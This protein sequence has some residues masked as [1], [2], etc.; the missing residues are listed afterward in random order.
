MLGTLLAAL[1]LLT[2]ATASWHALPAAP[3]ARSEVAAAVVNG[4]IAVVGGFEPAGAASP[5]VDW[6]VPRARRWKRLPDLPVGL[7]HAMAASDGRLLYVAGGYATREQG[8]A[9][10][11]RAFVLD[12]AAAD[13]R[14]R[15]LPPMPGAR[16]AGGAAFAERHLYIIAGVRRGLP[17][18]A[19]AA[20]AYDPGSRRWRTIPGPPTAREHLGVAALG[21]RI[22]ALGGRTAG[23][24][25]NLR[26]ADAYDIAARRWSTLPRAPQARGGCAAASVSGRVLLVG[27]EEPGGTI[28]R[29]DAFDP[30]TRR[31]SSLPPSPQPRHGVGVAATGG[32]VFQLL[33]GPRPGLT[34][35]AT[36]LELTLR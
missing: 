35:S 23:L 36:A 24:D 29:V 5:H 9:P 1:A 18:L 12:V 2:P 4:G 20:Y 8:F 22:Y 6:Y 28:A 19:R 7:H 17:R 33:G 25:T 15:E 31:W 30:R 14:W 34:T 27:G 16:A 10:S 32:S 26:T 3:E 21:G 11:R 13:A